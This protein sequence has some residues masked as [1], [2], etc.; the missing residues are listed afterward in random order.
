MVFCIIIHEHEWSRA[1]PRAGM[2]VPRGVHTRHAC[3]ILIA[4]GEGTQNIFGD[5]PRGCFDGSLALYIFYYEPFIQRWLRGCAVL[6]GSH[7]LLA[8]HHAAL[9]LPRAMFLACRDSN[10]LRCPAVW[11]VFTPCCPKRIVLIWSPTLATTICDLVGWLGVRL[12]LL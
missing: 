7:F 1:L 4:K 10:A 6:L 2:G 12:G 11:F 9:S 3:M 5:T 8:A